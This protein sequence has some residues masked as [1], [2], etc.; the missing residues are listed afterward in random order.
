MTWSILTAISWKEIRLSGIYKIL[1]K[2]EP[3]LH[4]QIFIPFAKKS[5]CDSLEVLAA[6][7]LS[8]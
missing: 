5:I 2:V 7:D 3:H 6:K 8:L 4:I 1:A